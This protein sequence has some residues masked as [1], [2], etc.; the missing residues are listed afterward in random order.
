MQ[1]KCLWTEEGIKK[2]WYTYTTEYHSTIKR[3]EIRPFVAT[4]TDMEKSYWVK[5]SDRP[6]Q[7]L[8]AITFMWDIKYDTDGRTH[9]TEIDS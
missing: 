9:K 3:D 7:T 1:P 2:M 6:R 4:W 5:S 8:Y